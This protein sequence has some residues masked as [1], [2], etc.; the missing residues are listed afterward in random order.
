[1]DIYTLINEF[2]TTPFL[3]VGSGFSRRYCNL[4]DWKSLLKVFI[5]RLDK[6]EYAFNKYENKAKEKIGDGDDNV[7]A[8]IADFVKKDFDDRW[9]DDPSFRNLDESHLAFVKEGQSPFKVEMAQYISSQSSISAEMQDE[10]NKFAEI[11][12]RS[13]SGIITTNYDDLIER[14]TGY[15]TF[16][17]QEELIFSP[18][19]GMAEV[20]KIHGSITNPSSILIT[21]QDYKKFNDFS[22]YLAAKLMTIFIEYPIVFIGYS[23]SDPNIH[24]ILESIVKCLSQSNLDKLQNRFVYIEYK[25]GRSE[26]ELFEHVMSIKNSNIHMTGIRTDNF[27]GIYEALGHKKSSLP[28]KV[29]RMFKEEFYTYTLTNE[30]TSKIRVAAIDD[31]RVND[32][33]LVLAIGKPSN[34]GLRGLAGITLKELYQHVV[35]HDLEFTADEILTYSFS[36][37]HRENSKLPLNRLISEAKND[38]PDCDSARCAKFEE[39]LNSNYKKGRREISYRS[40]HGIISKNKDN[41]HNILYEIP[42]LKE[43]EIDVNELESYLINLFRKEGFYDSLTQNEQSDLR[44]VVRIYDYLKYGKNKKP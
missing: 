14:I 40:I 9:F 35:L 16:V 17:G 30:P 22:S 1:M 28:A 27:M 13:I 6:D 21:N 7:L 44:R 11:S 4:P 24:I 15:K 25:Q 29:I 5:A 41:H 20:Y 39:I 32:E 8:V 31:N 26:I 10:L 34:F 23:L 2:N 38:Y 3:F 42:Y 37:L 18:I 19:Y 43:D 33:E 12:K 36:R